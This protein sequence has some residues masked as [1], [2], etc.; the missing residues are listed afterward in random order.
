M[1]S[2]HTCRTPMQ[3]AIEEILESNNI[4]LELF[5]ESAGA[6]LK[7]EMPSYSPLVIERICNS[8]GINEDGISVAHYSTMNGDLISDPEMTFD[9]KWKP[10][11][12]TQHPVNVYRTIYHDESGNR[13]YPRV[14]KELIA[15]SVLWSKNITNQG[16]KNAKVRIEGIPAQT[17][18]SK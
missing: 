16:W 12:I 17:A 7:L 18:N 4:P 15:F 10:T 6:Y 1:N 13:Y 9:L 5:Y 11:S 8:G 2:V 14:L 3:V